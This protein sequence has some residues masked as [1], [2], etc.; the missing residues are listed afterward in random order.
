MNNF[1]TEDLLLYLYN[2]QTD[3]KSDAINQELQNNWALKEK[4][5]VLIEAKQCVE[6]TKL[7]SPRRQTID[8]ILKYAEHVNEVT[9]H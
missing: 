2:E 7:Q 8:A 3:S 6:K 1:T 5:Q 9:P 4:I